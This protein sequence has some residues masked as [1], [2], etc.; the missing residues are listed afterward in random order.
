MKKILPVI[1]TVLVGLTIAFLLAL[2][3]KRDTFFHIFIESI[4]FFVGLPIFILAIFFLWKS[5]KS[6]SDV[7][8]NVGRVLMVVGS[9]FLLQWFVIPIGREIAYSEIQ[10]AQDYCEALIPALEEY[11]Q[12]NGKYPET[13]DDFLP[14]EAD[15]PSLLRSGNFYL[16]FEDSYHFAFIEPD[17]FIDRTHIYE[18]NKNSWQVND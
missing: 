4:V 2:N 11:K 8:S 12:A 17:S 1:V 13:L 5:K 15:L 16:G 10:K 18:S 6:S 9:I 7:F 14:P 3:F